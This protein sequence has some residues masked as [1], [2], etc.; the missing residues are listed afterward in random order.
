MGM[1]DEIKPMNA[2]MNI[3][4]Y[5]FLLFGWGGVWG[6]T[7]ALMFID[8]PRELLWMLATL[9]PTVMGFLMIKGLQK[10]LRKL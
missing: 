1:I 8:G 7:A 5:A 9:I 4:T 2:R 6:I 10:E 3:F